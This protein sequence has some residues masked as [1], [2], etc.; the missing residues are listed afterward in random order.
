[1]L[2]EPQRAKQEEFAA[3]VARNVAPF[4]E[5]WDREQRIP[6]QVIAE[7]GRAGYFG[8]HLPEEHGGRGWDLVTFGLL[9]E[10][11]GRAS[12]A[13]TGVLTVQSMVCAALQKW[14]SVEQKRAWL[15]SLAN[16]SIVGAFALTEPGAGSAMQTLQTRLARNGQ[17]LVLNGSK[18]WISCAQFAA[19]FLVFAKLDEQPIACLVPRQSAGLR[20][21][22]ITEL[23][24]FRAGG[25]ALLHFEDVPVVPE[26]LVG[27]AGFAL[28]HVAPVGLQQGRLS[29]ACSALGLL[30]GCFEESSTY[31][32][33]RRIGD[34]TAGELGMVRSLLTR[35]GV[36]LEAATA[37][38]R[39]A[40]R[41][42]QE[43][44]PEAI[45]KTLMAKY[46]A[47]RA[48]VRAA[49]DAVQIHGACGV[50]ASSPVS[51]YYR[52]ARIMEIIEGTTQVHEDLL[53][54]IFVERAAR[55]AV[56][57]P[58]EPTDH[59]PSPP[60]PRFGSRSG[61]DRTIQPH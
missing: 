25:L 60:R 38:C 28:S 22:P 56:A 4:A 5:A 36:D 35:M 58:S 20:V 31:A 6:A 46:F 14:G 15:P 59:E 54:G 50:H 21:E 19:V 48:A 47:S 29:T 32:A 39:K 51:R 61:T 3:F 33:T 17:G 26:N 41:S 30:R 45:E 44:L 11:F 40:C 9:H 53:G 12:S 24:G 27:R 13:L 10:A 49:G 42:A 7:M 18:K 34:A 55:A 8:G 16:G 23:M 37:L 52:D 1:V 57:G 43:R 2:S